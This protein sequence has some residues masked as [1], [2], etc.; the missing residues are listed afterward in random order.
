MPN[1]SNVALAAPQRRDREVAA[2]GQ[3]EDH[4]N[5]GLGQPG[6]HRIVHR[7]AQR[8]RLDHTGH[9][10][11]PH[12]HDLGAAAQ[13]E[14][15]F[16]D[17]L[18]RVGKRDDRC[19]QEPVV[20]AIKA[21]VLVEPQ[22]EGM[23]RGHRRL[24]VVLEG[25]LDPARERRQ[26]EHGLEVLLVQDLHPG[27]TVLVLGMVAEAVDLHQRR[28][29][30]ALGDLPAEQQIETPRLDDGIERRVRDEVV[31]D[32]IHDRECALPLGEHL[33]AAALELLGQMP[34]AGVDGL[35]VVV[36]DVDRLVVD[37]WMRD[38][39]RYSLGCHGVASSSGGKFG[40]RFSKNAVMPS[41]KSGRCMDSPISF[42]AWSLASNTSRMVSAYTCCLI[43]ASELGAQFVAMS[44]A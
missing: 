43:T 30:D 40:V 23:H 6:P 36:V 24:D 15:D 26:H 41:M 9:R 25:L 1:P 11:R 39:L 44:S 10:R 21:P 5:A 32:A 2:V 18:V 7:I 13:Y 27:I 14:L 33:H 31:D 4:R 17:G 16:L 28:R 12:A 34:G 38:P 37:F 42:S 22:V 19:R 29:V 8:A 3:V 20:G 35:V